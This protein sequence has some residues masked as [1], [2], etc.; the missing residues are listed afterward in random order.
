MSKFLVK[1]YEAPFEYTVEAKNKEEAELKAFN[2]HNPQMC[3]DE[4]YKVESQQINS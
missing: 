4:I 3:W 1:I 2:I